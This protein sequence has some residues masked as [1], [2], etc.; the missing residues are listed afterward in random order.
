MRRLVNGRLLKNEGRFLPRPLS[1]VSSYYRVHFFLGVA[2][3][4]LLSPP[5]PPPLTQMHTLPECTMLFT[6][7]VWPSRAAR[8]GFAKIFSSL[9][10][11]NAL[12]YLYKKAVNTNVQLLRANYSLPMT[13]PLWNHAIEP[14]IAIPSLSVGG[15][16]CILPFRSKTRPIA[17]MLL[18]KCIGYFAICSPNNF[19]ENDTF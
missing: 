19:R 7:S 12:V 2:F 18:T 10:A 8:K 9:V 1:R 4:S 6:V 16:C 13:K 17:K 11:F 3:V 5:P 15:H 14:S